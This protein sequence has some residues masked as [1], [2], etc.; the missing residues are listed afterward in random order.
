VGSNPATSTTPDD[1]LKR[2]VVGQ[3][4]PQVPPHSGGESLTSP[5][6]KRRRSALLIRLRDVGSNT[7]VSADLPRVLAWTTW[8]LTGCGPSTS[9]EV[10]GHP[11]HPDEATISAAF[12]GGTALA[13]LGSAR[14]PDGNP[15]PGHLLVH[16]DAHGHLHS[17]GD[18]Q[19]YPIGG[20]PT[21]F[22]LAATMRCIAIALVCQ[23]MSGAAGS[24]RQCAA[25]L[26]RSQGRQRRNVGSRLRTTEVRWAWWLCRQLAPR[27]IPMLARAAGSA[28][29]AA[30]PVVASRSVAPWGPVAP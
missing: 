27:D 17:V 21:K 4:S 14:G 8:Q 25:T 3:G 22:S 30:G 15:V 9:A 13:G 18:G 16:G 28:N 10:L 1:Q 23:G 20:K 11:Q 7:D 24:D 12:T 5:S 19:T 2:R 29:R 6:S 26:R